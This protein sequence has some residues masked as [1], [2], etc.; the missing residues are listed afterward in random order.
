METRIHTHTH[1]LRGLQPRTSLVIFECTQ[2]V[3]EKFKL[4]KSYQLH[5]SSVGADRALEEH[6][7]ARMS[8][9]MMS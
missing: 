2:D 4:A 9:L 3:Q 8:H 1:S 6:L 5:V 7:K